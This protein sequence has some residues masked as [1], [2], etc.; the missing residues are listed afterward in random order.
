MARY[1]KILAALDAGDTQLAVAFR[2]LTIAHDNQAEVLFTHIVDSSELEHARLDIVHYVD[3]SKQAIEE[4]LAD[5]L[6]KAAQDECIPA[7]NILV[8]GGIV[9]EALSIVAEDYKPDLV[10]CGARGLSGI[11]AMVLGSVST[12]LVRHMA[13]DVLVVRPCAPDD[14]EDL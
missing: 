1:N 14:A 10:I 11:K 3:T 7:V 8:R 9:N 13:C 12:Y 6:A 2:A 4:A 5:Q